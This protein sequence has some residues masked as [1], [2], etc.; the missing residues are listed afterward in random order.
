MS[1]ELCSIGDHSYKFWIFY[2][3]ENYQIDRLEIYLWGKSA[4]KPP[5]LV[6]GYRVLDI[7]GGQYRYCHCLEADNLIHSISYLYSQ[8]DDTKF[9]D[10][11][12]EECL[13]T[14]EFK[15]VNKSHNNSLSVH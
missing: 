6:R 15:E 9:I 13:K 1:Y 2:Q 11:Y 5:N 14:D 7:K 8:D 10:G 3:T 4:D 12:I